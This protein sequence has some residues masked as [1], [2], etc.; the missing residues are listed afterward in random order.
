MRAAAL[1]AALLCLPAGC[2]GEGASLSASGFAP[3]PGFEDVPDRRT[4]GSVRP[5]PTW[6]FS[7]AP[8]ESVSFSFVLRNDGSEPV[9]ILAV[10]QDLD[11]DDQLYQPVYIDGDHVT[12]RPGEARRVRIGGHIR[13]CAK[14]MAGQLA[15]KNSQVFL[16]G[17]DLEPVDVDLGALLEFSAPAVSECAGR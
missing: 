13:R 17:E 1:V 4:G 6:R 3:G 10:D 2:G 9:R 15:L 16:I 11:G 14:K 5:V 7:G 12:L 8:R